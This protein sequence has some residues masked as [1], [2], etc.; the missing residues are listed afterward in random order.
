MYHI[1]KNN[2]ISIN[3]G[4]YLETNIELSQGR[5]PFKE[6]IE[7]HEGDTIYF[8]LMHDHEPFE[9]S[10]LKIEYN[11]AD[12]DSEGNIIWLNDSGDLVLVIEPEDTI[13]LF[14]GVYYYE[15][16]LLTEDSKITT[17][18]PRSKFIIED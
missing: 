14:P 15:I 9:R 16:K 4:D 12:K 7:I 3:R 17:I 18:I 5:F 11:T 8:A 10:V 1:Y 2:V 13:G 6:Q